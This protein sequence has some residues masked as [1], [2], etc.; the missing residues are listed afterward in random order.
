MDK[1]FVMLFAQN[2]TVDRAQALWDLGLRLNRGADVGDRDPNDV[3]AAQGHILSTAGAGSPAVSVD[4]QG[5]I[6]AVNLAHGTYVVR[7]GRVSDGVFR[8]SDWAQ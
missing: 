4:D 5:R 2:L 6:F 8:A 7:I 1:E 3:A